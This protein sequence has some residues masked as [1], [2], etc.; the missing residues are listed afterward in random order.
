MMTKKQ[1]ELEWLNSATQFGVGIKKSLQERPQVF[2][3]LLAATRRTMV[4]PRP[5]H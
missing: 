5:Q 2:A 4:R 3:S 1:P